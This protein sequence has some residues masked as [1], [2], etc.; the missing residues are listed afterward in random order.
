[1]IGTMEV[2]AAGDYQSWFDGNTDAALKANK[3]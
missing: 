1:M 2:V 3:K